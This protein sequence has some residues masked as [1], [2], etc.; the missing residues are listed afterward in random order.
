[1]LWKY[2]PSNLVINY[3]TGTSCFLFMRGARRKGKRETVGLIQ[4]LFRH[5][6]PVLLRAR[7]MLLFL[8]SFFFFWLSFSKL[9]HSCL[10]SF[11]AVCSRKLLNLNNLLDVLQTKRYVFFYSFSFYSFNSVLGRDGTGKGTN[12]NIYKV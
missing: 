8:F 11:S 5:K 12:A 1:M 3:N 6:L 10:H 4:I 9:V 7:F 2:F